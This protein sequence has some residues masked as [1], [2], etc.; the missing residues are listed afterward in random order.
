MDVGL[1]PLRRSSGERVFQVLILVVM[2]VGLRRGGTP[3]GELVLLCLN[4][5]CNGCWSP[6]MPV[7]EANP[8]E[9]QSLNPCCNGCWSPTNKRGVREEGRQ[10]VLILVVM[11]VG[12]RLNNSFSEAILC[13]LILVVMDVGLRPETPILLAQKEWVLILVVMDVGLRP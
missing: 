7:K 13:V 11:D 5:C 1:R 3:A 6:T 12:L 2:D 9:G 4:P 8:Q 10:P